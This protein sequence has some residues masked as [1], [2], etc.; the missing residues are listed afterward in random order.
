M[1]K[2]SK[3]QQ[4]YEYAKQL[5]ASGYSVKKALS[6]ASERF[7]LDYTSFYA[8]KKQLTLLAETTSREYWQGLAIA[9]DYLK[10]KFKDIDSELAVLI[11]N[12]VPN[13]A[14][15]DINRA[16]A[17]AKLELLREMESEP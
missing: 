15:G 3:F 12:N 5:L 8:L 9:K 16:I 14:E 7:L 1:N 10:N 6:L 13:I 11:K 2:S 4:A 17:T